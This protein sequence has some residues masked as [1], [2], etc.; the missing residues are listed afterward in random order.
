MFR[1]LKVS[2]GIDRFLGSVARI[3]GWFAVALIL[4]VVWD[5]ITRKYGLPRGFGINATQLQEAEYWAHTILF[6]LVIGYAYRRQAHVRIDLLRDKVSLRGKY[7]IEVMGCLLF[8]IPYCLV[9]FYFTLE[10]TVSSFQEHEVSKS[11]IGLT[12]IW[13]LKAF[14]PILYALLGLAGLSQLIKS[15]AGLTGNLP[16][17]MI[18]ETIGGDS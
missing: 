10:Y 8:L 15:L 2:A 14:I 11:V 5:I 7:M 13:I 3:G 16:D 1:L 6:S 4:M 18:P 9:A 12:H 17:E